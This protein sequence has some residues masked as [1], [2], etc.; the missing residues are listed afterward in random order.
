[1]TTRRNF[2]QYTAHGALGLLVASALRPREA[3]AEAPRARSL[4]VLWMNG[5]PSHVDTFDPKKDNG[6]FK[7]IKTRAAGVEICEH[8]PQV[9]EQADKLAVVRGMTSKEGNHDRARYLAHTGYAP[10]PT[11]QHPALGAWLARGATAALPQFVSIGGPSAGGGFLGV[12]HGPFVLRSGGEL[13]DNV[14]YGFGVDKARFDRRNDGLDFLEDRFAQRTGSAAVSAR[15]DVYARAEKMMSASDLDAFDLSGEA[16]ATVKAYG[17]SEIGRGCLTARRLVEA[18]V[19]V[20][21]VTQN[22]WD[23]HDDG[24]EREKKLMGDLDPAMSSLLRDLADRDLLDTTLVLW[25][26]EFGRTPRINGREGRDHYPAAWSAV[27]AG[28]GIR[29]GIVHG[30]TDARGEKV[31]EG[32]VTIPDLFATVASQLGVDPAESLSTPAGRPISVTDSGSA[33]EALVG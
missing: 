24:F 32:A 1:M 7:A 22:G 2:L 31:V 15:R 25:M 9:A 20:V 18:G 12:D 26:G 4:V 33:V 17:D 19:R 13:P 29:G 11:V 14:A 8:L 16:A 27:L 23:T 30:A 5:G 28:G 3:A 10:N 21:E 6:P